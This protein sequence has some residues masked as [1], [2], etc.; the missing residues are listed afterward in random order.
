MAEDRKMDLNEGIKE[1][2]N[3]SPETILEFWFGS[4]SNDAATAKQQS[5]LWW[6][7][8]EQVDTQIKV[9]FELLVKAAG[10]G[11]LQ[12]WR[13]SASGQLALI[14]L[15]DQFPR[16]IYRGTPKSF[17]FDSVSHGL[18]KDGLMA[19]RD[20]ELRPIERVFFYMPLE[21]SE[22]TTDQQECVALFKELADSVP[23][24]QRETFAGFIDFAV[25]HCQ[26]IERFGRFPHR[27]AI[28]GR[29]S[30]PEEVE[31]LTQPGSSF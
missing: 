25:R 16:N 22:N 15:T 12:H 1:G 28:L 24:L 23:E 2:L 7:K 30:T 11:Q 27:N 31:F 29:V 19:R 8:Q 26:I 4:S 9:R 3:E 20:R 18:S 14:I 6:S 17:G 21:H 10:A 5:K 13:Q